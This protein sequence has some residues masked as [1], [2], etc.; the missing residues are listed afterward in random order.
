[1]G[2]FL[3]VIE[4]NTMLV[5]PLFKSTTEECIARVGRSKSKETQQ[6]AKDD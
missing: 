3:G 4:V 2:F 6:K 1:M 5:L